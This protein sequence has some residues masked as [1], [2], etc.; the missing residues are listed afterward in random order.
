MA[1]RSFPV[2]LDHHIRRD[3]LLYRREETPDEL[4]TGNE[5]HLKIDDLTNPDDSIADFLRKPDFQRATWSWSP[6]ECVSL[7]KSVLNQQVVPSV[8]LWLSPERLWYVLDGGH[9][10]SVVLAWI[11]DDWGDRRTPDEFGD[12]RVMKLSVEAGRRVR[13]LLKKEQIAP[14]KELQAA[15]KRYRD[16]A[17][18]RERPERHMSQEALQFSL[19]VRQWRSESVG[20]PILWVRGDYQKAE[21]SFI[22]INKS[23][24]RLSLWETTLVENRGSSFARAV[25][26]ISHVGD[27]G[28]CWPSEAPGITSDTSSQKY[29]QEI[30]GLVDSLHDL[31]FEPPYETPVKDP[32]Q[33]LL[34]PMHTRPELQPAWL[35][36]L[37]TITEGNKGR[38][39]ETKRLLRHDSRA[40]PKELI[41]NGRNLLR[42]AKDALDNII[43]DSPRSLGLMPL[44]YFYNGYG[45]YVRS[46]LY[47][48]IYWLTRGSET[49]VLAR[50]KLFTLH[51]GAFEEVLLAKK[52]AIIQRIGRRI[53]S[54][55]EVTYPTAVYYQ[56]L[57]EL[58][59]KHSDNIASQEFTRDHDELLETLTDQELEVEVDE[60]TSSQ[61][62]FRG[63]TRA[64]VVV[65]DL[66]NMFQKCG[67][68]GGRYYPERS[69]QVDHIKEHSEGG[70]TVP[71]NGRFLHNF[72][73]NNRRSI[74][75]IR[76]G[77]Q[78]V[79]MPVFVDPK[80]IPRPEQLSFLPFLDEA[81]LASP[82]E[83][84]ADS[85]SLEEGIR[86]SSIENS[87]DSESV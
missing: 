62:S 47:G 81:S 63:R 23:G 30:F 5:T 82:E 22:N 78:S 20:F 87:T 29:L 77:V 85:E 1:S 86:L 45:T 65:P 39:S 83:D 64:G 49:D 56:R 18:D 70:R 52:D 4:P 15:A 51:R 14:F 73:N 67:I 6:E 26:S 43:G 25:M 61:R 8:I 72:C 58:L 7:L 16:L 38:P 2:Y 27:K 44:V 66:I 28:H 36:E 68:C 24:R 69:T 34:A 19:M 3:N 21:E 74:E 33:P 37:L 12:E 84:W 60:L 42:N 31:L 41:I 11:R 13:E 53:G 57:L 17:K 40:L 54:G 79:E 50:K 76:S 48:M 75:E 71:S 55:P 46:L 32:V 80:S 59:I 9:R 35:A 10:I